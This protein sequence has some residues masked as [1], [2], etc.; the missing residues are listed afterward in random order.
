MQA[1]LFIY[2]LFVCVRTYVC[3]RVCMYVHVCVCVCVCFTNLERKKYLYLSTDT[4]ERQ[5]LAFAFTVCLFC[6]FFLF[7]LCGSIIN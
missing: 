6:C 5:V 2:F 3:M 7:F 4:I 1:N